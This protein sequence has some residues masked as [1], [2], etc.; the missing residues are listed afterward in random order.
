MPKMKTPYSSSFLLS[1]SLNSLSLVISHPPP[2]R[3]ETIVRARAPMWRHPT[4][5]A[6]S[7]TVTSQGQHRHLVHQDILQQPGTEDGKV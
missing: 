6:R 5:A 7:L 1:V 2:P 3:T 4:L